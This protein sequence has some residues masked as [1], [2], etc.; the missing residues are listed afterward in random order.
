VGPYRAVKGVQDISPPDVYIWQQIEKASS[1]VFRAYGF[2]EFR[3]PVIEHTEV[4]T[5][6]IGESTDIVDKEMYTFEDKGGR[7]LSLRP[8]G[9][10]SVVRAYV[11]HGMHTL[12]SP[13]KL[14][15]SGPM[16]RYERPQ[17]GRQR[18]FHQI[19]VEAFG[20]K[21]PKLDAEV[22]AML[23]ELLGRVGLAGLSCELNSLG[24]SKCR[25]AFR[26]ELVSFFAPRLDALCSDCGNRHEKNPLRIL[27][28]KVPGCIKEREG[29]PRVT[30]FLCEECLSHFEALQG[31]LNDLRVSFT[32]NPEMV[33][34]LDYYT[35]TTFEVTSSDLGAQNAV[36]A[37]GRYDNLVRD[38]GGPD[39]P[40]IGFALG[41][42]R[43]VALLSDRGS[44][45][46]PR[47]DAF[48]AS[49]GDEAARQ[50]LVLAESL[51]QQGHWT[52]ISYG[53]ASLKNQLRRADRLGARYVF[54]IGEDEIKEGV[55]T[56]KRLSDGSTGKTTGAEAGSLL[57]SD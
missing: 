29:A 9:T 38:F 19:G 14:Y 46:R 54:I 39:T 40:A 56:Y 7:S 8:E 13:Q 1:E 33:R 17:K 12:P 30:E 27:D 25:P 31:L 47:P 57:G 28:C 11:Q 26:E 34:G 44:A 35:S 5:R 48:V 15:Y 6:S 45:D 42:E 20:L 23:M 22:I 24:C 55:V 16:F 21:D 53:S 49:V 41:I 50:A 10:A 32:L 2:Q 36:A 4:F 18:Q 3:P 52:E 43:M 51:R 37:G